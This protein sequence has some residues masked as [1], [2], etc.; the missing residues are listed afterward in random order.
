MKSKKIQIF[1]PCLNEEKT[2]E[3]VIQ[4]FILELPQAEIIVFDNGSEDSSLQIARKNDIRIVEVKNKGKG[5]VIREMFNIFDGDILIMVDSDDT[6]DS[7]DIKA[8]IE[9]VANNDYDMIISNRMDNFEKNSFKKVNYLGNKLIIILVNWIFNSKLNDIMSGYRVMNKKITRLPVMSKFFQIETE[10]TIKALDLGLNIK[11][12]NSFYKK[13]PS[14]S[15][16]KLNA[17]KDGI[18]VLWIIFEIFKIYKPLTFFGSFSIFL[19]IFWILRNFIIKS[20]LLLIDNT[21]LFILIIS[22]ISLITGLILNSMSYF[23]KE[24][25]IINLKNK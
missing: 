10:L 12:I 22:L 6:Y 2:L 23:F 5:H 25:K 20:P 11:N 13:R 21:G 9:P 1:L 3:N 17:F 18:Q 4:D 24:L 16:S 14:G 19:F 8:L 15:F 7:K